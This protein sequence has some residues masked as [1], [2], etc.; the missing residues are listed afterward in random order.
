[1]REEFWS[2]PTNRIGRLRPIVAASVGPYGAFLAD[3]S[4]YRGSYGLDEDELFDFHRPRWHLLAGCAPDLMACETIPSA[5]E[6]RALAR[7]MSETP[8]V[9]SWISFTCRDE[10]HLSDGTPVYELVARLEEVPQL[11][12][13]GINCTAPRF[14]PEL[15]REVRRATRKPVVVYPNSGER[16]DAARR[17]WIGLSVPEDFADQSLAWRAAGATLVGGCC[18]TGPRHVSEIRNVQLKAS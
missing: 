2:Q 11:V 16:W 9:P 17:R 5:S 10:R 15:V 13:V 7:L 18:R 6:A 1:A 4:E 8:Q 3:G 12:A 14:I